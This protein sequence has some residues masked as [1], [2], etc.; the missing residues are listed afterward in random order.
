M[1]RLLLRGVLA[2]A[3]AIGLG[4][5]LGR[6][7]V[8]AMLPAFALVGEGLSPEYA[9]VYTW[10]DK[11]PDMLMLR[12]DLLTPTRATQD[13]GVRRGQVVTT[14]TNLTHVLVPP[15]IVLAVIACWPLSGWRQ[16]VVAAALGVPLAGLSI[17]LTTP[18][19]LAGKVEALLRAYALRAGFERETSLVYQW[20]MMSEGGARW[21]LP[22]L[23]ALLAVGIASRFNGNRTSAPAAP[24]GHRRTTPA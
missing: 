21:A 17:L 12:A 15:V 5:A 7:A 22:L 2:W 14:G 24:P 13:A 16:H 20:M 3:L 4:A 11:Q 6:V 18:F 19:L 1:A 10:D 8:D 23:L 9:P